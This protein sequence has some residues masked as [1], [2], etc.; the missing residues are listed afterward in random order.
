MALYLVESYRASDDT[1]EAVSVAGYH[2]RLKFPHHATTPTDD[3]CFVFADLENVSKK[4]QPS[5]IVGR[6]IY[7]D[8]MVAVVHHVPRSVVL[9]RCFKPEKIADMLKPKGA[10]DDD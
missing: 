8:E 3:R 9:P 10:F 4:P 7:V 2:F 5:E 6:W 1:F